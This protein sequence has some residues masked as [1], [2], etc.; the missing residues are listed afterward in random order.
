MATIV[1]LMGPSCAGKTSLIRRCVNIGDGRVGAVEVGR[2]LRE[3][4]GEKAFK[5]Q[6]APSWTQD[7]AWQLYVEGVAECVKRKDRIIIVDGQPRDKDQAI[8]IIGRW[9]HPHR[10][11]FVLLHADHEAREARCRADTTSGRS[12]EDRLAR[13]SNDYRN[14]Y[15]VL[16]HL[17]LRDQSIRVFDSTEHT[18]NCLAEQ[19]VAE[20]MP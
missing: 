11:E 9:R 20:Y 12:L 19:I 13:L 1:H 18:I 3:K 2:L 15:T 8:N 4:H 7:E 16:A 14:C 10:S 17:L 5:G 6:A